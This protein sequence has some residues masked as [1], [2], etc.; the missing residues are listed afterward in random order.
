MLFGETRDDRIQD[1]FEKHIRNTAACADE[2]HSLFLNI[3]NGREYVS[4]VAAKVIE[5]EHAGDDFKEHIHLIV[6]KTFITRLHKDDIDKLVHELDRVIDQIKKVV[7][8]VKAYHIVEGRPEA[9]EFCR[10]IVEMCRELIGI[11]AGMAKPDVLRL[12]ERVS[13]IEALE[14]DGDRLLTDSLATVFVHEHDAK[15]V[16]VWQSIFEKLEDVT[17]SCHHVASLA[18]SIARKES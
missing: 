17:D 14:E 15:A 3:S 10:L 6:D 7:I 4:S 12:R 11:I 1:L 2:L 8:Y 13:R 18:M 9:I 5:M 16:L